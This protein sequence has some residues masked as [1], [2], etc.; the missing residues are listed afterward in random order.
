MEKALPF[1]GILSNNPQENPGFHSTEL[2]IDYSSH[3]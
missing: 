3:G 2:P 1:T